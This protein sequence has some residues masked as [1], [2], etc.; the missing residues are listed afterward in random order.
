[1]GGLSLYEM[2]ERSGVKHSW[3]GFLPFV[4]TYYAGKVAGEVHFFGKKMKRAGLYAM[5]AEIVYCLLEACSITASALL[6]N[7]A[8]FE[9]SYVGG[10]ASLNL[11]LASVPAGLRWLIS[12]STWFAILALVCNLVMLVLLCA[13]Y[14]GLYRKYSPRNAFG[15]TV[16]SVILPVRAFALFAIRNNVPVDYDEYMKERFRQAMRSVG[17]DFHEGNPTGTPTGNPFEGMKPPESPFSEFDDPP[18]DPP[19]DMPFRSPFGSDSDSDD[20]SNNDN[21]Q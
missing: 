4:N 14:T 20:H 18:T 9:T 15:L 6:A 21:S 11:D 1:M 17:M 16:V 5:L 3:L 13:L 8:Y 10:S 2:A 19:F 7:P 12:G